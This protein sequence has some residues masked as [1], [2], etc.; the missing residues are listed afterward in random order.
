[1]ILVSYQMVVRQCPD[2]L[3]SS[4]FDLIS[5]SWQWAT[6]IN[7][8]WQNDLFTDRLGPD[9]IDKATFFFSSGRGRML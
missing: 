7:D 9:N 4:L 5:W 3:P 2:L 1:M 6:V 8:S